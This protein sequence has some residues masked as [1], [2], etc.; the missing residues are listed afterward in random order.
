MFNHHIFYLLQGL[1]LITFSRVEVVEEWL[2]NG[3]GNDSKQPADSLESSSESTFSKTN[4]TQNFPVSRPTDLSDANE[5]SAG[6]SSN[7]SSSHSA[8]HSG[9][10]DIPVLPEG[11]NILTNATK[12]FFGPRELKSLLLSS[13]TGKALLK[14]ALNGPLSVKS[15]KELAG[16]IAD[17]HLSLKI[18]ATHE[19]LDCYA[20]SIS[21]LFRQ[22]RKVSILFFFF[23]SIT[24]TMMLLICVGGLRFAK[25]GHGRHIFRNLM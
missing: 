8:E 17:H 2:F 23:V 19:A 15:Q 7:I 5:V 9:G 18:Q 25:K 10:E 14:R 16:I 3:D 20:S 4:S 12:G 21:L 13:E 11:E 24:Y 1:D 22:E 6:H